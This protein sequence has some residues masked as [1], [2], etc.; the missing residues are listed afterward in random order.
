M[1]KPALSSLSLSLSLSLDSASI[2]TRVKEGYLVW[3]NIV[4]HIPK[5]A[6]YTIGARIE[7]KF[8]DLLELSYAT[9]FSEREK[10]PDKISQCIL[11]LDLLKFLISVAWEAK[12]VSHVQF[13]EIGLKLNEVGKMFGGWRK[14][15][16]L[17]MK[18]NRPT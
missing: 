4:P 14:N 18:K 7:H 11:T 12:L 1:V 2:L 15:L 3:M 9:Y 13:E 6:R 10:K 16:E 8:L 5:G 17:P